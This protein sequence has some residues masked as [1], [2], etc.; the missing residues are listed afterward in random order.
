[1]SSKVKLAVACVLI[2]GAIGWYFYNRKP[3]L[4]PPEVRFVDVTTGEFFTLDRRA[5]K[6][7]PAKSPK[8]GQYTLLPV[9]QTSDGRCVVEVRY[10]RSVADIQKQTN[11]QK[12]F[13]DSATFEVHT[14]E[15]H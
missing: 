2:A 12:L 14:D 1:M 4:Q 6:M 11:A 7:I 15:E 5:T 3:P 9:I 10:R 8:T 13:V